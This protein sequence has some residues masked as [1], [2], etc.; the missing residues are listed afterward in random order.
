MEKLSYKYLVYSISVLNGQYAKN[1]ELTKYYRKRDWENFDLCLSKLSKRSSVYKVWDAVKKE[2]FM[3][4]ENPVKTWGELTIKLRR[5]QHFLERRA[6]QSYIIA[7]VDQQELE[8]LKNELP[9]YETVYKSHLPLNHIPWVGALFV[10]KSDYE[11]C[12]E[13]LNSLKRQFKGADLITFQLRSYPYYWLCY[14]QLNIEDENSKEDITD[15]L[16][17]LMQ[18]VLKKGTPAQKVFNTCI[19]CWGVVDQE[20]SKFLLELRYFQDQMNELRQLVMNALTNKEPL[21]LLRL[22]DGEAYA[23]LDDANSEEQE[24]RPTLEKFWWGT[25]IPEELSKQ[26]VQDVRET[27]LGADIIG[28]PNVIR[29]SQTLNAAGTGELSYSDKRQNILFRGMKAL[30]KKESFNSRYWVD[31]YANYAFVKEEVLTRMLDLATNVIVVG[32]FEIPDDNILNHPKVEVIHIPPVQK[33]SAVANA[34]SNEKSMPEILKELQETIK[35][36]LSPGSLLLLAGGFAGKPILQMAKQQGAVAIDFGS[37]LDHVL[38]YKTRSQE[39]H[40][41]FD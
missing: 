24:I 21:S 37:G 36:K 38:G 31:E 18:Q 4:L 30:L 25:T 14:N 19:D 8:K 1:K 5:K 41:L 27:I 17:S 29:L 13:F 22:G 12:L 35:P 2:Y 23:F 16:R 3:M 26:L 34:V 7:L 20:N 6:F 28:L 15:G 32:C 40:L 33:I 11:G 39:L 9:K 10:K